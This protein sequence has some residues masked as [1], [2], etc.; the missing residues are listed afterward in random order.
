MAYLLKT[1]FQNTEGYQNRSLYST[2]PCLREVGTR[3]KKERKKERTCH[4]QLQ[5]DGILLGLEVTQNKTN[6]RK[7]LFMIPLVP[8]L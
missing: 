1:Q 5:A 2:T 7:T 6:P 8:L 4:S 3:K